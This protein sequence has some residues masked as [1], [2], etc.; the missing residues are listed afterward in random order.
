MVQR[1]L[2]LQ[3]NQSGFR[4]LKDVKDEIEMATNWQR[5]FK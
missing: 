5:L 3:K 2:S 4:N 1:L